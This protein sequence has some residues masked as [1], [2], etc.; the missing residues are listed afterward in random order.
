[1]G[2]A[3]IKVL[4]LVAAILMIVGCGKVD[5]AQNVREVWCGMLIALIG[6]IWWV[7]FYYANCGREL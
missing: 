7:L 5:A 1:M 3:I 2:K 6:L 4:N